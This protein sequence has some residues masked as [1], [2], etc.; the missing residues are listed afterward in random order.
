MSTPLSRQERMAL[1]VRAQVRHAMVESWQD[2]RPFS[3]LDRN[4]PRLAVG[5]GKWREYVRL[6]QGDQS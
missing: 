3:I 5:K 6:Q 4:L 2:K 1:K